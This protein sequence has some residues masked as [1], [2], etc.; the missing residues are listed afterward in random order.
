MD[1][2]IQAE[3]PLFPLA[4]VALPGELVPLHIFEERYKELIADV[5]QA[6]AEFGV[7][8]AAEKG[9]CNTGCT[10]RVERILERHAD[11]RLDLLA[12]GRRRFEIHSLDEEK[13]Y[14]RGQVEFFDDDEFDPV[15][16][17]LK[18]RVLEGYQALREVEDESLDAE[19]ADPQL[20]FQLAQIVPDLDFRQTLLT[21]RS[22]SGRMK[23]LAEF[24]PA[25]ASR[26]RQVQHVKSV[27]PKNGHGKWPPS[28]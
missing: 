28:V 19:M 14:L 4:I 20:S 1:G 17:D 8:L 18:R 21:V 22:E 15:P 5:I 6:K 23:Q 26:A 7:V 13:S 2:E 25:F 3:F 11:G 24:F 9:I 27:A 10:A 16:D 12:V